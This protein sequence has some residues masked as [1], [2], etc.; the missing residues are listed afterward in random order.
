[1]PKR[2]ANIL[3]LEKVKPQPSKMD[4]PGHSMFTALGHV[5]ELLEI[6]CSFK[7]GSSQLARVSM[8]TSP[9]RAKHQANTFNKDTLS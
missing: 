3:F 7:M 2:S 1:M 4:L 6:H 8:L 9:R 5:T